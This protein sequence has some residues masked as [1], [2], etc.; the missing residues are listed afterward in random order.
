MIS[1]VHR[2]RAT[3]A[4]SPEKPAMEFKGDWY[5][6]G[7]LAAVVDGLDKL[8]GEL[9]LPADGAAACLL[10]NSPAHAATVLGLVSSDRCLLTINPLFPD[11]KL[12]ED[13]RGL[14]PP[15]IVAGSSDWARPG[16]REVAA[17]I[18]AAGIELTG[19]RSA[20]IRLTPGFERIEDV[21]HFVPAAGVAVYM[22]TSGTTGPP[23][24]VPLKRASLL[25]TMQIALRYRRN[26]SFDQEPRLREAVVIHNSPM[27]HIAGLWGLLNAVMGGFRICML[28]KF[29]VAEWRRAVA[30]HKPKIASLTPSALRMMLDADVPREELSSLVALRCSSAPLSAETIDEVGERWGIPVLQTYGATE[31]TN[32]AGWSLDDFRQHYQAHRG[33]VGRMNPGVE[34]RVV[35]ESGEPLPFGEEGTLELKGEHIGDGDWVRT[36]DRAVLDAERFLWIRGRQDNVINRGGFKVHC[37]EVQSVLEKHPDV[38]EVSVVGIPDRRLGAVPVAAVILANKG[39]VN[40]AELKQWARERM[41]PYQVPV[42][43]KIVEDLPRTPSMKPVLPAIRAMFAEGSQIAN[44]VA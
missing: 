37:E 43:F 3:L 33:S 12:V 5:T 7:D 42:T 13:L 25:K 32:I 31:F 35:N 1:L 34:A 4:L 22:L 15:V 21:D 11:E 40:E 8:L 24:R 41:L 17:Q 44:G 36:T 14:R 27:V 9:G 39:A 28:E 19:D 30:V 26:G 10:R 20:P 18:G 29:S 6:W 2:I 16:L 38:R 23:K